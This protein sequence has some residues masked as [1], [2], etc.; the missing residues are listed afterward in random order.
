MMKVVIWRIAKGALISAGGALL[1]ALAEGVT[2]AV[3]HIGPIAGMLAS[4]AINVL[5]QLLRELGKDE[6]NDDG[7]RGETVPARVR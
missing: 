5:Y 4:N 1:G 7:A 2:E 3:P 6:S